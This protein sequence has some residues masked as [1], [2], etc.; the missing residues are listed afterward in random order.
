M[1]SNTILV[2]TC[3]LLGGILRV[4][5]ADHEDKVQCLC[6]DSKTH[7][8]AKICPGYLASHTF[9]MTI[10]YPFFRIICQLFPYC[11][12][13]SVIYCSIHLYS[14]CLHA[15]EILQVFV[16]NLRNNLVKYSWEAHSSFI[17]DMSFWPN[18]TMLATASADKTVRLWDTS[19]VRKVL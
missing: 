15:S 12:F 1:F 17:T 10:G 18:K 5:I 6:E 7:K 4:L 2:S 11:A 13:R 9:L 16:W 8:L 14:T 19:K 3:G